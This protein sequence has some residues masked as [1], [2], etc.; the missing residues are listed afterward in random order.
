MRP[1]STVQTGINTLFGGVHDGSLSTVGSLYQLFVAF[2]TKGVPAA[3]PKMDPATQTG[4]GAI[5]ETAAARG[6]RCSCGACRACAAAARMTALYMLLLRRTEH[7]VIK[8]GLSLQ[9]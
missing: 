4:A 1:Y 6:A 8:Q 2:T 9:K 5:A 7:K 3:P